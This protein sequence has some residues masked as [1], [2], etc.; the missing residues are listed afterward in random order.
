MVFCFAQFDCVKT[1]TMS[2]VVDW[3]GGAQLRSW[4]WF[5]VMLLTKN[6]LTYLMTLF[7][8]AF[9][10]FWKQT[11]KL[12]MIDSVSLNV[13]CWKQNAMKLVRCVC[14]CVWIYFALHSS[15]LLSQKHSSF[16]CRLNGHRAQLPTTSVRH[17]RRL[18]LR[19]VVR[20]KPTAADGFPEKPPEAERRCTWRRKMARSRLRSFCFQKVPRWTPRRTMAGASIREACARHRVWTGI[21]KP[22]KH[23]S[24]LKFLHFQ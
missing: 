15:K 14:D 23:A 19:A 16:V 12:L 11:I 10:S 9:S 13:I 6:Y 20:R 5:Q 17:P 1:K 2:F 22:D 24:G 7:L 21:S 8:I 3:T 18:G 4:T